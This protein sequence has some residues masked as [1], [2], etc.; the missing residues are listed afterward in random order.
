MALPFDSLRRD[1]SYLGRI[2]GDTLVEQEGKELLDLE[3]TIRALAKA[4]RAQEAPSALRERSLT[5]SSS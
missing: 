4:R 3:E 1:V 2:L 5:T